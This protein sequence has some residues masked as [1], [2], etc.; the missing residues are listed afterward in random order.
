VEG[1]RGRATPVT[2]YSAERG[3]S[4]VLRIEREVEGE[5]GRAAPVIL[6]NAERGDSEVPRIKREVEGEGGR[7]GTRNIK[8][9]RARRQR[10]P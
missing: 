3:D 1:E 5:E 7:A 9:R 4:E 6:N 2:L 10:D 8:W